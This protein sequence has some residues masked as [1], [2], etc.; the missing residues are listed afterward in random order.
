MGKVVQIPTHRRHE[1]L[2]LFEPVEDHNEVKYLWFI[3]LKGRE[4]SRPVGRYVEDP[5]VVSPVHTGESE[6]LNDYRFFP[7]LEA[8]IRAD[9]CGKDRV[10]GQIPEEKRGAQR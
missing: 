3:A 6:S 9:L 7:N 4:E 2:Q 5:L 10:T 8:R 1:T